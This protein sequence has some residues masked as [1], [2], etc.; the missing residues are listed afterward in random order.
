MQ[1]RILAGVLVVAVLVG[2]G[3][4][5]HQQQA[6]PAVAI[7]NE[8]ITVEIADTH[9][10]QELGLGQ[11][12][13]LAANS[14]ML[15][16]FNESGDHPFWMKDTR[17]NLDMIWINA[18][19]KIVAIADNV[20]SNTYPQSFRASEPSKYVLEVNGGFAASRHI[21]VGDKVDFTA[22]E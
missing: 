12:D 13:S 10:E 7:N 14:G 21:K 2:G 17:F 4:L 20:A 5:V 18:D 1:K 9:A 3:L 16:V 15:F 22:V 19:K 8:H 11:R 6:R